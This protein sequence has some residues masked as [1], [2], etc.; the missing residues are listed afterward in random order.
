[1][2]WNGRGVYNGCLDRPSTDFIHNCSQKAF[3]VYHL[4][5]THVSPVQCGSEGGM[6]ESES[7]YKKL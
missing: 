2:R 1:M 6:V 4:A 5:I 3:R 7:P